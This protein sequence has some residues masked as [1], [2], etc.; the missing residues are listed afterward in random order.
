MRRSDL[1]SGRR[2]DVGRE[3]AL[4]E[5]HGEHGARLRRLLFAGHTGHSAVLAG[6]ALAEKLSANGRAVLTGPGA[7]I[8]PTTQLYAL[9]SFAPPLH[10]PSLHRGQTWAAVVRKTSDRRSPTMF[11]SPVFWAD[12]QDPRARNG[13]RGNAQ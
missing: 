7:L 11:T 12:A 6:L 2:A 8:L 1:R 9:P 4:R 3:R 10:F 5:R 13:R